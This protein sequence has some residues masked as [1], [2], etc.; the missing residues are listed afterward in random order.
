MLQLIEY[1]QSRNNV[2]L[3]PALLPTDKDVRDKTHCISQVEQ[4]A[5][6]RFVHLLTICRKVPPPPI[7]GEA[8]DCLEGHSPNCRL[9]E[10]T[11]LSGADHRDTFR[12]LPFLQH[13]LK[14]FV[15]SNDL[16]ELS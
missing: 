3:D 13:Y 5:A 12:P 9:L 15:G 10:N 6:A 4:A 1:C 14:R 7:I 11:S 2:G 8:L 16:V